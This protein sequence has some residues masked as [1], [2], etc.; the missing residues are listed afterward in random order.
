MPEEKYFADEVNE[1]LQTMVADAGLTR[2]I[3]A[4]L[5]A[6]PLQRRGLSGPGAAV[7]IAVCAVLAL[8]LVS[9]VPAS[10]TGAQSQPMWRAIVSGGR[11]PAPTAPADEAPRTA[12][13][14]FPATTQAHRPAA[15]LGAAPTAIAFSSLAP[16][17]MPAATAAAPSVTF[18]AAPTAPVASAPAATPAPSALPTPA[19][20]TAAADGAIY[21]F[22]QNGKI[23]Y[24]NAGGQVVVAPILD[25]AWPFADGVAV[26]GQNTPAGPRYGL[27]TEK[28]DLQ[29]I[30]YRAIDVF[31]EGYAAAQSPDTN[32]WGFIN[33]R[34]LWAVGPV[35][36]AAAPFNQG[37]ATVVLDGATVYINTAGQHMPNRPAAG[38]PKPTAAVTGLPSGARAVESVGQYTVVE[39][40]VEGVAYR[41]VLDGSG[42][43]I[44]PTMYQSVSVVPRGFIFSAQTEQGLRFGLAE[45][46]GA[47]VIRPKFYALALCEGT[48]AY[49]VAQPAPQPLVGLIDGSG[50]WLSGAIYDRILETDG[51]LMRV[52]VSTASGTRSGYV[53]MKGEWVHVE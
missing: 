5:H 4:T 31:S 29:D 33:R 14:L 37:V 43:M 38:T 34:G 25:Y 24:I 1:R 21:R 12:A 27:L 3:I 8:L 6:Q 18:L 32:L 15:T 52:E 22:E 23:G 19:A 40:E 49:Y 42:R 46:D 45:R 51:V 44:V 16:V 17:S 20:Q 41:G 26:V 47:I 30:V 50:M 53:N 36:E 7:T 48:D 28:G 35:F 9:P 2:R 10:G 11:A 39:R 13:D